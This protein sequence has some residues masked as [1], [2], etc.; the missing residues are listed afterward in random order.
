MNKMVEKAVGELST[1]PEEVQDQ[2]A[3][4]LLF[5]V[6]KWL[7]LKADIEEGLAAADRGEVREMDAAEFIAQA[8]SRHARKP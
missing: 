2:F 1:L 3:A 6:E 7:A 4:E 8:R 5:K